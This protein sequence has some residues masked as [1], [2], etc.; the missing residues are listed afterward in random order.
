VT[1]V[2]FVEALFFRIFIF[3]AFVFRS[4]GSF[5]GSFPRDASGFFL[6]K[7]LFAD[8]LNLS[9]VEDRSFIFGLLL[10]L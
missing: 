3:R 1:S 10:G 9:S 7:L 5:F 8:S 2:V 6:F 4:Q